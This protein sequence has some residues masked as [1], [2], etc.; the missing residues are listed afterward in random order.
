MRR[1]TRD[2]LILVAN[3]PIIPMNHQWAGQSMSANQV[4]LHFDKQEDALPFTLAASSVMSGRR[5][6]PSKRRSGHGCGRDF[7]S[8]SNHG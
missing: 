3:R 6:G 5:A 8:Q 4:V 2:T 7:Q 1:T